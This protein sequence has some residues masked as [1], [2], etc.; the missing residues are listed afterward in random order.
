MY[1]A[2][3]KGRLQKSKAGM[4]KRSEIE[5]DLVLTTR[6]LFN[7]KLGIDNPALCLGEDTGSDPEPAARI[8]ILRKDADGDF[9]FH[10]S[11]EQEREGHIVRQVVPGGPAYLA[12]LR[13]GDQLLQVNGEYVHE[14]EYL[15]VVQ[16]IKYS[17]SRLSLGVLDE[18]AY[19][20]L[21]SSHRS[22]ASVLSNFLS[23]SCPRP[24]FYRVKNEGRGFG[25]TAS[26]TGGVRGTFLLQVEDGGPA[27][28]AGVPHGCRLLEVN[29][30]STISITLS[31]L[32]KKLQRR[33]SHVVLL[34]LEASAWDVY[35]SHGV[36][37][38][39]ALAETSSLPYRTRK[40]HLVKG[41]QGYGFLL[42]QEKCLAGQGQ[43]LREIDPGLPAEDAG[44][45]E[46][47]RLLGVN[48]QS[49]EGLEHE[50]TV[51]MIQESGKQV[52][53]IVISNEGDR[54]FNEIGLSP[55]LFYEEETSVHSECKNV[56][57]TTTGTPSGPG[58]TEPQVR[59]DPSKTLS[60][61][62]EIQRNEE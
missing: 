47:D 19:E 35:E 8:C 22:P 25:F 3:F 42:R 4:K 6:F 32:T 45:R 1:F 31:Q 60:T 20:T 38:S 13:D 61:S 48:G 30:E 17:G 51:S 2:P 56:T 53:L 9:A 5:D 11:K 52:T 28:K 58:H 7:P 21:R 40:L 15:R 34:V 23:D 46:G 36:P 10:L 44:M 55:L 43:F 57:Q 59:A 14:Q 16:K 24:H 39:A 50:D 41:P 49:V 18:A 26:A 54:F 29:G 37:L 62:T 27:Q 33:S 12:G